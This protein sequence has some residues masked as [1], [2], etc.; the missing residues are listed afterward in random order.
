[1]DIYFRNVFNHLSKN[2]CLAPLD[3]FFH[4][5]SAIRLQ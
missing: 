4:N 2:Q 3:N 5:P 1:L